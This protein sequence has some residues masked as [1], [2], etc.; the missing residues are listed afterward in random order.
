MAK[1]TFEGR[2]MTNRSVAMTKEQRFL[3]QL[4]GGG[5]DFSGGPVRYPRITQGGWNTSVSASAGTH[6][7][8]AKDEGLEGFTLEED[9]LWEHCGWRVGF[10]G[11]RR[12]DPEFSLNHWHALAKGDPL[13]PAA[14]RQITQW[15]Q[16]DN[17]L[18]SDR[19][20]PRIL[21]SGLVN[22]TWERYLAARPWDGVVD[23]SGLRAAF[24][25]GERQDPD[26]DAGDNDAK[27]VQSRLNWFT[28]SDLLVDGWPGPAT[29]HVY[30]TFQMRLYNVG[31]T[32]EWADGIPGEHSLT[33]IGFVVSP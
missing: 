4:H 16:G 21:S 22:R 17:A 23:L 2:T 10:A 28:G 8:S 31:R 6:A 33:Q 24:L 32:H 30:E 19:D 18:V 15:Y 5:L 1:V 13:S 26:Q 14:D 12:D 9:L 7:E 25:N 20:Y 27:Q 29:R 11:W 3:F